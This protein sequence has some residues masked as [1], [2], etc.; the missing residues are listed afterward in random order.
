M[1][2]SVLIEFWLTCVEDPEQQ[3]QESHQHQAQQQ[4]MQQ[5]GVPPPGGPQRKGAAIPQSP[6]TP[7]GTRQIQPRCCGP[8][9]SG[10]FWVSGISRG[11]G[12]SDVEGKKRVQGTRE[13]GLGEGRADWDW[14]RAVDSAVCCGGRGRNGGYWAVGG[15]R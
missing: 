13:D 14:G 5:A 9:S 15:G 12:S 4:I 7:G 3:R 1:M 2:L 8:R 11:H 6:L 10:T